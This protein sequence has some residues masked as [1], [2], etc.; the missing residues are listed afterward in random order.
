MPDI[1]K[2]V[3][4][5]GQNNKSDTKIVQKLLNNFIVALGLPALVE[6]GDCGAKTVAAI[7][8]FQSQ[9]Q[10]YSKPD[11]R[12]DP[13]GK[14]IA[15]LNA[16]A[17][18]SE[19]AD[20]SQLSGSTWW[21]ANQAKYAN[22]DSINDLIP[23]FREKV[24]LF[25][26]AMR[27]AGANVRITSTR[28][29]RIRAYLMHYCWRIAG[30]E[31]APSTVPAEPGC[32]IVW[33]HG[34]LAAS[35]KAAQEM[36]DLFNIAFKPSLTSRHIDGKAIDMTIHWSGTIKVKDATGKSFDLGEPRS[37]N[38]N[39]RLHEIGKSYGVIKLLKDPPHWS[40]DGR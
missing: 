11:G 27:S 9:I 37:G 19:N 38:I 15:A 30:N 36:K 23:Q 32:P 22:S 24:Q 35:R 1:S 20:S 17:S 4:A 5:G 31:I 33:D 2:S 10:G 29:N 39:A 16:T 13:G 28:R 12:V 7:K 3:G 40:T 21:H 18:R 34:N 8:K 14:T 25:V 6:D 26:D